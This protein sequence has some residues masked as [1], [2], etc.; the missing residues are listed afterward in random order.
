MYARSRS[1]EH[2]HSC[3]VLSVWFQL[4]K[5]ARY[6]WAAHHRLCAHSDAMAVGMD[7]YFVIDNFPCLGSVTWHH[8]SV[9]AAVVEHETLSVIYYCVATCDG[10][11]KKRD[12]MRS[13][14]EIL[15]EYCQHS[16]SFMLPYK[17]S[18]VSVSSRRA[19][20]HTI[21]LFVRLCVSFSIHIN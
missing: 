4:K 6:W 8:K 14:D 3:T 21:S 10:G 1:V 13:T 7:F 9:G 16:N 11:R 5:I 19:S 20:Q 17:P 2:S 15:L 12:A 18:M